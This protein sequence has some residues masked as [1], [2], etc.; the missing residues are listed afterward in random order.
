MATT[1][2]NNVSVNRY[3]GPVDDG[4]KSAIDSLAKRGTISGDDMA[5]LLRNALADLDGQAAGLEHMDIMKWAQEN[6]ARLSPEA[7]EMLAIYDGYAKQALGKGQTGIPQESFD[8]MMAEIESKVKGDAGM[9][10]AL[11]DLGKSGPISGEAMQRAIENGTKDLDNQAAGKEFESLREWAAKPENRDRLTPQAR[12][13]LDIYEN[14]ARASR[15]SGQ[16]GIPQDKWDKMQAEMK[17]AKSYSDAGAGQALDALNKKGRI[18]GD[19]VIDAIENG[20]A[21]FDGQAAGLEF[22]DFRKWAADNADRLGPAA[23][24]VMSLY[25]KYVRQAKADGQTGIDPEDWT[26]MLGEMRKAVKTR[27]QEDQLGLYTDHGSSRTSPRGGV[28]GGGNEIAH[29]NNSRAVTGGGGG[30]ND[31]HVSGGSS[32]GGG[33]SVGRSGGGGGGGGGR[34]GGSGGG[35]AERAG[36]LAMQA[37]D[38]QNQIMNLDPNSPTYKRDLI[39]LQQK[40]NQV[41]EMLKLMS[42]MLDAQHKMAESIIQNIRA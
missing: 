38:L 14:Y 17:A 12:K 10:A 29:S 9:N 13:I 37:Q 39:A 27:N 40:L 22:E 42:Q 19:D 1:V 18:S 31:N 32:G 35:I 6:K 15:A 2:N 26:K 7:Q 20:T 33:S 30:H 16:T 24:D 11:A 23:K 8:Q 41:N 25:E 28:H 21:D 5:A 3:Q 34:V 4:A 36:D